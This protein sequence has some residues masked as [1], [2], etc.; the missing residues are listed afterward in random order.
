M[1]HFKNLMTAMGFLQG[2]QIYFS[3]L[4]KCYVFLKPYMDPMLNFY[5]IFF[6]RAVL[7]RVVI[8]A[9]PSPLLEMGNSPLGLLMG[10]EVDM[11]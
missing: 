6:K 11:S 7:D 2:S 1:V 10:P 9:T 5:R 3:L 4:N 8:F